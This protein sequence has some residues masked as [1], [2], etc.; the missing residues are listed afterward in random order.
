MSLG[1]NH[2]LPAWYKRQQGV[3]LREPTTPIT[4]RTNSGSGW[5]KSDATPT[6]AGRVNGVA[7]SGGST[8]AGLQGSPGIIPVV[9]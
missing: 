7:I 3:Q 6:S 2:G 8:G 1:L 5:R 9:S 4:T